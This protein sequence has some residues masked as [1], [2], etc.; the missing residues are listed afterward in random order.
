MACETRWGKLKAHLLQH[1][2]WKISLVEDAPWSSLSTGRIPKEATPGS[3]RTS[4]CINDL[5]RYPIVWGGLYFR[6]SQ[7]RSWPEAAQTDA[8]LQRPKL[9]KDKMKL[10]LNQVSYIGHLPTSKGLKPDPEKVKAK[11]KMPKLTERC[12]SSEKIKR[13]LKLPQQSSCQDYANCANYC[14]GSPWKMLSG[15]GHTV[16]TRPSTSPVASV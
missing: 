16:R 14:G 7:Q 9:N 10:R 1:F 5:R 4:R 11:S 6:R 15:T 2:L 3:K 12:S 8:V 13:F